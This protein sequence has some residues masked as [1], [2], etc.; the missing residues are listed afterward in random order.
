[1]I[2]QYRATTPD[3]TG[4]LGSAVRASRDNDASQETKEFALTIRSDESAKRDWEWHKANDVD[5]N[6]GSTPE[7]RLIGLIKEKLSEAP[8]TAILSFTPE[9]WEFGNKAEWWIE[10]K[11][12]PAVLNQ[13]ESEII[14]QRARD[15]HVGITWVAGLVNDEHAPPSIP[16]TWGLF[17]ISK[18]LSEI[19]LCHV[20]RL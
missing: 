13:L 5:R 11:V 6:D 15:L 2:G 19:I 4:G 7:L 20:N 9:D 14:A 12:P 1:V 10:C 3:T 18:C 16:T 17:A 8:P